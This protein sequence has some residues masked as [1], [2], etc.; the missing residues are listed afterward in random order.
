VHLASVVLLTTGIFIIGLPVSH[1]VQGLPFTLRSEVFGSYK[2][3]SDWNKP[4]A[5]PMTFFAVLWVVTGWNAPSTVAEKTHNA[6]IVAPRSIISTYSIQASLGFVVLI[7]LAF[8]ITDIDAAAV[9]E[10]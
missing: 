7:V 2:N 3:Y 9:D 8:C 4:V 5:V 1:A 10:T 6:S